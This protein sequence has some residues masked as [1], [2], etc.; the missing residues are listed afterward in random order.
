MAITSDKSQLT[1]PREDFIAWQCRI[2]QIAMRAERGRPSPG[3]R[4]RVLDDAG[5]ELAPALTV[6]LVPREPEESTAF[7]RFQVMRSA[8]PRDLYERGLAY[9]QADYF[10]RPQGFSDKMTA[11]LDAASPL[12]AKLLAEKHCVLAFDQFSQGWLLPCAVSRL[13]A[14]A[15][16]RA[17][18]LWHNRIFNPSLP[19]DASVLQ[20]RPD[21][22]SA[23]I[24]K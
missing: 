24:V 4:P 2:R 6:L 8:D 18:S 1:S 19:D 11:V 13:G 10:H 20:F 15:A 7:F 12:A 22:A 9:L 14:D 21:W 3:M 16:A 17:A 23:E 5:G